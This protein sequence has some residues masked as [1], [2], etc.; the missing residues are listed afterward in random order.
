MGKVH[1]KIDL[2]VLLN[3]KDICCGRMDDT[4]RA[5]GLRDIC[6]SQNFNS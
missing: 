1:Q 3:I 5:Q 2:K 4:T 6:I